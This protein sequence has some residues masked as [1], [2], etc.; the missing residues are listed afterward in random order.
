MDEA[1]KEEPAQ[2]KK[3]K[4]LSKAGWVKKSHGRLLASYKDRYV[5][6][7][8]TEMVVYENEDLQNCL[9]RLDLESYDK[10][11]EL[12]SP[13]NKKHRLVLIRSPK[14]GNKIHDVK[15]QAQT[16][17]EKEAWIKA[18]SDCISRAKNKVFDEVKVDDSSNLEHI[19]R[20]RPQGNRNRRPPTRIHMREV[21]DVSSDGIL[22]LDLDLEDAVMPN[23]TNNAQTDGTSE[24]TA[25]PAASD[26]EKQS[27]SVA[28]EKKVIKPPMP[29][30]KEAK[31][32]LLPKNEPDKQ[33]ETEAPKPPMPPSKQS[34]PCVTP[35]EEISNDEDTYAKKG[36]PPTPPIKPS[37]AGSLVNITETSPTPH[38]PT[39]PS[40]DKKPCQPTQG[41]DGERKMEGDG[42]VEQPRPAVDNKEVDQL[43]DSAGEGE[44][45]R[46]IKGEDYECDIRKTSDNE[47]EKPEE[48][49]REELCAQPY[50]GSDS[51]ASDDSATSPQLLQSSP[52]MNVDLNE[53]FTETLSLS[54]LLCHSLGGKEKKTEEKS[55][56][57]GQHSDDG[58]EGSAG[59]DTP[60]A[61]ISA[62]LESHGG[63]D[64]LT[65]AE[66]KGQTSV[67]LRQPAKLQLRAN[68]HPSRRS[69]PL[70]KPLKPSNKAK[71]ASIGDLLSESLDCNQQKNSSKAEDGRL[72]ASKDYVTELETEVALQMKKTNE[73]LNQAQESH[74]EVMPE[75]LLAKALEKL[76]NADRVLREVKKLKVAKEKRMSW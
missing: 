1:T 74:V 70:Q 57:S 68:F 13:F 64:E 53:P 6:V 41:A 23:G 29:P 47:A 63:L 10:C 72:A 17:E 32:S 25:Y 50:D 14:S 15:L 37:S 66:D 4:F 76:Q 69:E 30:S 55:V 62:T 71:S 65:A 21:A 24:T 5:Q 48:A 26:G 11:H 39:P 49:E 27:V 36:T 9:E 73:L 3:P 40:K 42:E 34:K 52:Q 43:G 8:K 51:T 18:L 67:N 45:E 22:R 12:K 31:S 7:E 19:T 2:P 28:E 16:A 61:S 38:P 46:T 59:E 60:E 75:D 56:D 20:T 33:E 35:E 58:S 54:P 44:P